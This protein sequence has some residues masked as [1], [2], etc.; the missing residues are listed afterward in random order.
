M[1]ISRLILILLYVFSSLC[2]ASNQVVYFEPKEATLTGVVTILTFPGPPNYQSIKGGDK[3]ES[4]PYLVLTKPINIDVVPGV[5]ASINAKP[6]KDV[7]VLQLVVLN[8][9]NWKEIKKGNVVQITGTLSASITGHHHARAL[10]DVKS[11][12]VLSKEDIKNNSMKV[13]VEDKAL[14]KSQNN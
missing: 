14:L 12:K 1:L 7:Q 13:T 3:A 2:F 8:D 5:K 10:L 6:I 9:K 11:V 4:G